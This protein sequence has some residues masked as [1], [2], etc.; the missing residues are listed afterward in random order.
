MGKEATDAMAC[1]LLGPTTADSADAR[2]HQPTGAR[3]GNSMIGDP[4]RPDG[5]SLGGFFYGLVRR[6]ARRCCR[7]TF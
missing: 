6:P 7:G 1:G 4:E 3:E 2:N 5:A